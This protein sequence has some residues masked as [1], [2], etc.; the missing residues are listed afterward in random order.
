MGFFE[1]HKYNI[2]MKGK[3]KNEKKERKNERK[4]Q[5]EKE[6]I[7][8]KERKGNERFNIFRKCRVKLCRLSPFF[9]VS[10]NF[11]LELDEFDSFH[12]KSPCRFLSPPFQHELTDIL[13][14][15]ILKIR[16][17]KKM[18]VKIGHFFV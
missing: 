15:N 8:K 9:Q 12:G 6:D 11:T 13:N 4:K 18:F 16:T 14:K 7:R 2:N 1:G 10:Q 5:R 17:L 3:R